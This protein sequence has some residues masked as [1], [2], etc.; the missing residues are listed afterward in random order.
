MVKRPFLD[1][2]YRLLA[3]KMFYVVV[4]GNLGTIIILLLKL[5]DQYIKPIIVHFA[6]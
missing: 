1:K 2:W 6:I 4:T 3:K 5:R